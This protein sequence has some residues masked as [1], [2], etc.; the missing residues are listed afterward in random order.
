LF[1]TG[2]V[3][4][5][6]TIDEKPEMVQGFVTALLKGHQFANEAANRD[7]V[8]ADCA[9][10]APEEASEPALA[11]STFDKALGRTQPLGSR[12]FG[13]YD[14]AAW[15]GWLDSLLASGELQE[16]QDVSLAFTNT[17]VETATAALGG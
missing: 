6:S 13:L 2:V 7:A 10:L 16:T 11:A 9:V 3:T 14:P 1:G 12:T 4:M 5:K 15:Q 8:L 17:F